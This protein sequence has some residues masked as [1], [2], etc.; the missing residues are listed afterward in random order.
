ASTG[1][2]IDLMVERLIQMLSA[3][4][5]LVKFIIPNAKQGLLN[6]LYTEATVKT[7]DYGME[8]V[9]V[10]AVVDSRVYGMLAIYE[11]GYRKPKEDWED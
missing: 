9:T 7:V 8:A 1:Q 6:I 2:G 10:E 11:E 5:R 3:G 4:K